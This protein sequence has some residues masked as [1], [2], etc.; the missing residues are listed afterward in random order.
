MNVQRRNRIAGAILVSAIA[1][2]GLVASGSFASAVWT[3]PLTL[4]GSVTAG[5]IAT[6]AAVTTLDGTMTNDDYQTTYV[7]RVNNNQPATSSYTGSSALSLTVNPVAAP[8]LGARM[9]VAV[10]PVASAAA[11]TD[12]S[13]PVAGYQSAAWTTGLTTASVA[14][15]PGASA[16]FCTR[17]YPTGSTPS[18]TASPALQNRKVLAFWLGVSYTVSATGSQ[19]F[20]PTYT[21]K[22]SR[23]NFT[24][25]AT[26][27]G[28][29]TLNTSLIFSSL[30]YADG[31]LGNYGTPVSP[32]GTCWS[33]FGGAV[34][35]VPGLSLVASN[36][37]KVG[38]VTGRNERFRQ[39]LVSG[40]NNAIQIRADSIIAANGYLEANADGTLV[41]TQLGNA[42]ELRQVWIMQ[43]AHA[44]ATGAKRQYVQFVNAETGKCIRA[45]AAANGSFDTALCGSDDRF[46]TTW[47]QVLS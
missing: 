34:E 9:S 14:A 15:L 32:V 40:G 41:Q 8:G 45:P 23:G 47:T 29:T 25:Q 1:T 36:T 44:D 30:S 33:V 5:T 24:A 39:V 26:A 20:T 19:S 21:A 3:K 7:I 43:L 4:T 35:S 11:C 42:S 27:S 18:P 16:Y 10:W 6:S 31:N 37:C 28:A 38:G 12:S 17:G 46:R 2:I 13:E 22:I